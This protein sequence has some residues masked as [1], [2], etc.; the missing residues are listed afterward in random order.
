MNNNNK[1]KLFIIK[2]K[3]LPGF[4]KD[5]K[6][7][8]LIRYVADI[9]NLKS[10]YFSIKSRP[11]NMTPGAS[12]ETFDGI[13]EKY[14]FNVSNQLLNGTF[15]FS[16]NRK[17]RI[18][19]KKKGKRSLVIPSPR[20]KIVLR[21]VADV[22][23][24][25]Y[26][27]EFSPN[28]HGFRINRG[29]HSALKQVSQQF[30]GV[31]WV[32]RGDLSN[33]FDRIN[34]EILLNKLRVYIND[35]DFIGLIQK[36]LQTGYVTGKSRRL[37]SRNIGVPQGSVLS[38]I[39]SNIYLHDFDIFMD[40]LKEKF[41]KG[42]Q[43]R[44]NPE[45][46]KVQYELTK[47]VTLFEKE[48]LNK[49]KRK[50]YSKD[51]IDPGF[52]R[53]YYV[54]YAD[55]F[56]IG[57]AG[58]LKEVKQI[59]IE[60]QGKL[61]NERLTVSNDK[62]DVKHVVT[63]KVTFLGTLIQRRIPREKPIRN[64]KKVTPLLSIHAPIKDL[65]SKLKTEGFF[66]YKNYRNTPRKQGE[67]NVLTPRYV[68]RLVNISHEDILRYYNSVVRGI[69]NYYSFVDNHK[70]L[71]SIVHGLKH[72]CALTLALKY[73]IRHRS[74]VFKKF[75]KKLGSKDADGKVTVCFNLPDTFKRTRTFLI[76]EPKRVEEVLA[77]KWN[78]KFTESAIGKECVV[79]QSSFSIE[80]HHIK[81]IKDLK[82]KAK[83]NFFKAQMIAIRRKQVP[84]CKEHHQKLHANS[85]TELEKEL[86][87]KG[88]HSYGQVI[89]KNKSKEVDIL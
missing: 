30:G 28:S 32:T 75:G 72:S 84:L 79:C 15:K 34:H 54:R 1:R 60:V 46:R 87:A 11:S 66:R 23:E 22:L 4:R 5:G 39:L 86:F 50:L 29:C 55:D 31:T 36:H 38:P 85:F 9:D 18:P 71:G 47:A 26:N 41:Y 59:N 17:V 16:I 69:L 77:K 7:I 81:R 74:K 12:K 2:G 67:T 64:H 19:K 57:I 33:F 42:R 62:F 10:A 44:K 58:T 68:G 24:A 40:S 52:R 14:F 21:V 20:D 73:K 25:I 89:N 27:P 37:E 51:W 53:L 13:D 78:M 6:Y 61:E 43:R 35:E 3:V 56:L 48:T 70:S 88:V 82:K 49:E 83:V 63:K 65:F 45:Y 80:I 8:S 76:K